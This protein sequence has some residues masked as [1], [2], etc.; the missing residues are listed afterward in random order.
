M[1]LELKHLAPYLPYGLKYFFKGSV[2]EIRT[3]EP[4]D[5]GGI[6]LEWFNES[7][8]PILRPLSDLTLD[9]IVEIGIIGINVDDVL[10]AVI[11]NDMNYMEYS[12]HSILVKNHFDV[13]R[14]IEKGLA[15]DIN[16]LKQ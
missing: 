13:F 16:T 12:I 15:I 3:L 4:Q 1:K 2:Q 11:H 8:K 6:M 9:V 10:N 5:L 14:L 7:K